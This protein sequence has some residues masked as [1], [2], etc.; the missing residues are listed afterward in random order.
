[1]TDILH[2]VIAEPSVVVKVSAGETARTI[3]TAPDILHVES[4]DPS[5][6]VLTEAPEVMQVDVG[7]PGPPGRPGITLSTDPENRARAGADGGLYVPEW[8][9]A[10]PLAYYLLERN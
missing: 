6:V 9:G 2:V 7:T 10:A 5:T 1:M 4:S 3:L 8:V